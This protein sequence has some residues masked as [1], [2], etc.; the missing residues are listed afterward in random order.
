[1]SKSSKCTTCDGLFSERLVPVE[2]AQVLI[3]NFDLF[4]DDGKNIGQKRLV[5]LKLD[6]TPLLASGR[7]VVYHLFGVINCAGETM[8]TV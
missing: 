2:F 3:L 4:D 8:D 6:L 7:Q 5:P 1:M